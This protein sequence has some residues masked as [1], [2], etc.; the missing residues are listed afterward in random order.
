VTLEQA[1]AARADVARYLQQIETALDWQR[2]GILSAA[3]RTAKTRLA[4]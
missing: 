1:E 3:R 4:A 2:Q